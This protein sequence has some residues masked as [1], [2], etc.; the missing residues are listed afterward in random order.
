MA[1]IY[2]TAEVPKYKDLS[3]KVTFQSDIEEIFAKSKDPK[4]LE[5]YWTQFRASTGEKI[6]E[7]YLEYVELANES[8][9]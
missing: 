9:R 2:S 8:A 7:L 1:K 6:R 5:Y 3:K 4:K